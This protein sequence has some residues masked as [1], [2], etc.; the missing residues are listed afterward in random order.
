V[1]LVAAIG[2]RDQNVRVDQPY[3]RQDSPEARARGVSS[4]AERSGD[5]P[6]IGSNSLRAQGR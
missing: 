5:Q 1:V 3:H 4:S 2:K 6:S